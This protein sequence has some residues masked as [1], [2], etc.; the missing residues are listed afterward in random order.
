MSSS[1]DLALV[2]CLI[3][4]FVGRIYTE[5]G[6]SNS[7]IG[8]DY[9]KVHPNKILGKLIV[10]AKGKCY[11]CMI[12]NF[13]VLLFKPQMET[14]E[15]CFSK[16]RKLTSCNYLSSRYAHTGPNERS[17][18]KHIKSVLKCH[19]FISEKILSFLPPTSVI[20][21]NFKSISGLTIDCFAH[22]VFVLF[23]FCLI[24]YLLHLLTLVAPDINAIFLAV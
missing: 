23:F 1:L 18:F 13:H 17:E 19:L 6:I 9:I 21:C 24:T 15:M 8:R 20:N 4:C 5:E 2:I 22:P 11:G 12:I 7:L 3:H 14:Q 10:K 16:Q